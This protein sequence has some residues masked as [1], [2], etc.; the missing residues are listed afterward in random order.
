MRTQ[1]WLIWVALA[2][3][4][5]VLAGCGADNGHGAA[6]VAADPADDA[7]ADL[8][9]AAQQEGGV[10]W[11][12]ASDEQTVS[13]ITDAFSKKYG[14]KADYVRLTT[15]TIAQRYSAEAQAGQVVAD[16]VDVSNGTFVLDG[17]KNG[18]FVSVSKEVPGF[19]PSGFNPQFV[20][21]DEGA[22]TSSIPLKAI[23]YNSDQI[24][25]GDV[26]KDWDDLLDPKW[27]GK[28]LF[29]DPS[30]SDSYVQFYHVLLKEYG[31]A[32]LSQL[33]SQGVRVYNGTVPLVQALAAGEG[34]IAVPP[35]ID[36]ISKLAE[37]GAPIKYVV[38]SLNSGSEHVIALSAKAP[39]PNAARLFIRFLLSREGEKFQEREGVVTPYDTAALPPQYRPV[40]L[41]DIA[42]QT[43]DVESVFSPLG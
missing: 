16:F 22:P 39:H 33:V 23:A 31:A 11:Y 20:H 43:K 32:F 1:R 40:S 21:E 3:V 18:T 42:G 27:K 26:P 13:D 25:P 7:P 37:Q 5:A 29:A 14:I 9:A 36:E 10:L 34:A 6:G 12:S 15:A 28:I 8:V 41:T 19:P 2:A 4:V 35:T 17:A 38:P 24:A 30:S